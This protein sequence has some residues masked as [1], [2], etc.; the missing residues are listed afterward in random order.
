MRSRRES[1]T[2]V[3]MTNR[4]RYSQ[5]EQELVIGMYRE[6]GKTM[7]EFCEGEGLEIERVERWIRQSETRKAGAA[8]KGSR[9]IE[10]V[11]SQT[12]PVPKSEGRYRL[13]FGNGVWLEIE[14][15]FEAE[16]VRSLVAII[17]E[18]GC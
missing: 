2:L 5:A 8:R 11:E 1:V 6:S 16:S 14:G 3:S 12:S 4:K 18:Q 17:K 9:F 15:H 13:G 10:V 7:R